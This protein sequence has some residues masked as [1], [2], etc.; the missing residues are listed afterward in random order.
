MRVR[1]LAALSAALL[2]TALAP[3]AAFAA[4]DNP[5]PLKGTTG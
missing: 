4:P 1:I 5:V 3:A 2:A